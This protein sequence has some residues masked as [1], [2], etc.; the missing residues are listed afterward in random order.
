MSLLGWAGAPVAAARCAAKSRAAALGGRRTLPR[1]GAAN[2]E[3][4]IAAA[5]R[6][7]TWPWSRTMTP[8]PAGARRWRART[9]PPRAPVAAPGVVAMSTVDPPRRTVTTTRAPVSSGGTEYLFPRKDTNAW[10]ETVRAT[11]RVAGN[12]DGT[13]RRGSAAAR[14]PTVVFP[15]VVDRTRASPRRPGPVHHRWED[16][17]GCPG[18][19]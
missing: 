8:D 9:I 18:S 2:V 14:A 19:C 10:A 16:H 5:S 12:G 1:C 17:R 15:P 13:G 11:L 3:A 7:W 4:A 6:A